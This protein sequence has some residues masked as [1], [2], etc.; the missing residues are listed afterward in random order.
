MSAA[1]RAALP[2]SG[3][4]NPEGFPGLRRMAREFN[5]VLKPDDVRTLL[6]AEDTATN[7]V[8]PHDL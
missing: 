7:A 4:P 2:P 5:K 1:T 6:F 8:K 3:L